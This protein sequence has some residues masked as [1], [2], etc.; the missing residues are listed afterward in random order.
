MVAGFFTYH[1]AK[2]ILWR[3]GYFANFFHKQR[4]LSF[5]LFIGA[6]IYNFKYMMRALEKNDLLD[7]SKKR[8]R[9]DRDT[10]RVQNILS[11]RLAYLETQ[12]IEEKG[13]NLNIAELVDRK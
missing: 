1:I 11:Q 4:F 8:M 3:F 10:Q 9:Y 12:E 2:S 5:P 13:H 6:S 7:Y